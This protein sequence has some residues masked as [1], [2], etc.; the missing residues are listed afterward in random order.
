MEPYAFY[1][2]QV[3]IQ[4]EASVCLTHEAIVQS[5]LFREVIKRFLTQLRKQQSVFLQIFPKNL[6]PE[7]QNTQLSLL[8]KELAHV[9]KE[10]LS[11][12]FQPFLNDPYLLHQLVEALYTYWRSYERFLVCYTSRM[13]ISNKEERTFTECVEHINHHVRKVYRDIC[14]HITGKKLQIYRQI[15]AGCQVGLIVAK[16]HD[17]PMHAAYEQLHDVPII[18]KILIEPPL[19]IDP[20]TNTRTGQFTRVSQNPMN[21]IQL[22]PEEWLCY[23]AKVGNLIIHTYFHNSFIGL[24]TSLANLFDIVEEDELTKKPDAIF[25]YGATEEALAPFKE[26]TILYEDKENNVLIG[27]VP[28]GRQYAYFGYLKKMILTL[29]NVMMMKQ[30][31]LPIHGAMIKIVLKS[32]KTAH[33][34]LV[35]D[36]GTGKSES[37]EAFRLLADAYISDMTIIFD[38]MGSLA[39]ENGRIKAYGTETGAFVRLDDL[40]V[41]YAFENIDRSI[42]MSPQKV[43]A[44]VVLP[45]TTLKE[46]LHGYP[47]DFFLYANNYEQVSDEQPLLEV[48]PTIEQALHIFGQGA[49]M[50]K[51]T[52][53]ETGLVKSYFANIFGPVQYKELHDPLAV[54]YFEA[55]FRQKTV[56]GQLR[57][58][59]GIS[60]FEQEGPK[61]AAKA[62]F[63][64]IEKL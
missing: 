33:V 3:I 58:R 54:Q 24:G 10:K 48:V 55:L 61:E 57:T 12:P 38:D 60:G 4:T 5:E 41:G 63:A 40:Q 11:P 27:V 59:L 56:V 20:P 36:T 19:I 9:P 39:L 15:P 53:S 49:R 47:V 46:V 34:V 52:T 30:G 51:G 17:F 13:I 22:S 35:G 43:N 1:D 31:R 44:R 26:K 14:E 6:T 62:L 50:S 23:P 7:E 29:H 2:K 18:D 16:H 28:R 37:L 64:M 25:I 32:G 21:T 8:L 42:I 45:I